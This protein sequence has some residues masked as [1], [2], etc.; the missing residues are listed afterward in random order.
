MFRIAIILFIFFF[1]NPSFSAVVRGTITDANHKP[2]PFASVYLKNTTYGVASD[3]KGRYYINIKKEG[4]CTL[5][6]SCV[7]YQTVEKKISVTKNKI[8][9]LNIILQ[10]AVT[11]LHTVEVVANK[12]DRAH[13]LLKKV[14]TNR[15]LYL[16]GFKNYKC[17]SYAKT[18]VEQEVKDTT[19]KDTSALKKKVLELTKKKKEKINFIE[20]VSTVYFQKPNRYKNIIEAYHDYS[21]SDKPTMGRSV[22][23]GGSSNYGEK[24]IAPAHSFNSKSENIFYNDITKADF[25]FYK[26]LIYKQS[27]CVQPLKSPIASG[28]SLKY[29]YRYGGSFFDEQGRKIHKLEV[30]PRNKIDA[31]FYGNI[32]IEDSTWAL[33]SVDLS[34]NENALIG[35]GKFKIMETYI[36]I[37]PFV[38]LPSHIEFSYTK[39]GT[40]LIFGNTQIE[41]TDYEVDIPV[42]KGIF[43]N[44]IESYVPDFEDKDSLYWDTVRPQPLKREEGVFVSKQDSLKEYYSSD[45]FFDKQDSAYSVIDW[46]TPLAGI[47]YKNHYKGIQVHIG[48]I[49]E[50]INPFGVGGYRH[51]LP[52]LV[53]KEFKNKMVLETR[54]MIDYGFLNQDVKG[55]V[56]IG[57]MYYPKKFVKTSIAFGNTY[58]LINN[59]ASLEQ[60]FSRSNYVNHKQIELYQNME[61]INGLYA[62]AGFIY[63]SQYPIVG[64]KLAKW[65]DIVFGKLNQPVDFEPYIKSEFDLR[66]KYVF[67]QWYVIKG[68]KKYIVSRDRPE[69]LFTYRKGIP[70]LF[71]SEVNFDYL[72][73]TFQGTLKLARMGTSNW[74]IRAGAFPNKHNLRLLEYK[75]FRGS[76]IIFFSDPVNSLQLLGPM[77]STNNDFFQAGYIHHFNGSIL[78]KIPLFKWLK[79]SI[80]G[81][82]GVL[83]MATDQFFH[84][85][86]Y[87]GV[88]KQLRIDTQIFKIGLYAVSVDGN[89]LSIPSIRLKIGINSYDDYSEKWDY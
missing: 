60:V 34:I 69:L 25:N 14:Q 18:S 57:F 49:P 67:N 84:M 50:Q 88:E 85:E 5:V 20:S 37:K 82:A 58:D 59:Y 68:N 70:A 35:Y 66:L 53:N 63:S 65:S 78:N 7:G 89:Q 4:V 56:R 52:L 2:I 76:D 11:G 55:R 42:T 17:R 27:L 51:R 43:N 80:A 9:Y 72:E 32:F 77:M 26:N 62:E 31:L 8:L 16:K 73:L 24:D 64:L 40:P 22:R 3:F 28:A 48:G 44:E 86:L 19:K 71:N 61:L 30:I 81:G 6:F 29:K 39:K 10:E 15:T 1:S 54:E 12:Q 47:G 46:W 87:A 36:K 33:V 41:N 38:Y 74:R 45:A 75:Y 13:W 23:M 21:K 83:A 79:L